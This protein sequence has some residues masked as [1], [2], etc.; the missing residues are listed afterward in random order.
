MI[1]RLIIF[2]LLLFTQIFSATLTKNEKQW[3]EKNKKNSF[4]IYVYNPNHIYFFKKENNELGGVYTDFFKKI[5]LETGL[6]FNIKIGTREELQN[7]LNRGEGDILFNP[8]K[9]YLREQNYFFVPTLN[10]YSLGIYSKKNTFIDVDS[11]SQYRLGILPKTSDKI[12]M[13]DFF[14]DLDNLI[15]IEN[16]G[17]FGFKYLDNETIDGL[18]GKSSND[19]LKK[20]KFTP[21]QDIPASSLWMTVNKKLPELHSI[22]HKY[23]ENFTNKEIRTS[24]KKQRP[25]FYKMLLKDNPKLENL[26][27][28]YKSI[29]VLVPPNQDMLPLFYRTHTG[30]CGYIVDRLNELSF[31]IGVP[32]VYTTNPLD[33]YDIKAIDSNVFLKNNS[34]MYIPYYRIGTAIFSNIAENFIDSSK[35]THNKKVGLVSPNDFKPQLLKYIP[36][37]KSYKTYR[38][39]DEALDA[40]LKKEIDYLYGDFKITSMAVANRYLETS[41]KVSGFIDG[42]QTIGFGVKD[43]IELLQIF[44]KIFPSHLAES[45]IL[46]TELKVLK[47]L[48]PDYKYLLM[49]SSILIFIIGMLSYFLKKATA[50]SEKEKRIT[51]ALVHSFEAAN[52][53][54]DEDT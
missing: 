18:I 14:P 15:P 12:L 52:E 48:N 17:H 13:N 6:Q 8:S 11:L 50:A 38:S 24:L 10:T 36:K 53:L 20:Y 32:I 4:N 45:N 29:K 28:R 44:D 43:D 31:L 1:Y 33:D 26:K 34:S 7:L 49:V 25:N 23:K 16:D 40:L 19:V 27:K 35:E 39:T 41:I 54:N 46:Q 21:L 5:S 47:K 30:Y 51:R 22:I 9:T 3:I 37:F 2:F 42:N